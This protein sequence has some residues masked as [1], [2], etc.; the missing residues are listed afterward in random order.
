MPSWSFVIFYACSKNWVCCDRTSEQLV[1]MQTRAQ[2]WGVLGGCSF[3]IKATEGTVE[4]AIYIS[5]TKIFQFLHGNR[6]TDSAWISFPRLRSGMS[7]RVFAL[8]VQNQ[9]SLQCTVTQFA[10]C[11]PACNPGKGRRQA[12]CR[13]ESQSGWRNRSEWGKEWK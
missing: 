7:E 10:S 2:C 13:L 6:N 11:F 8:P 5:L 4:Y 9:K 3:C 1:L 12:V